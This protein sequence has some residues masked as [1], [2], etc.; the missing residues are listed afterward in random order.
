MRRLQIQAASDVSVKVLSY[1]ISV[2]GHVL[3]S[4]EEILSRSCT[5]AE[6][7]SQEHCLGSRRDN[8]PVPSLLRPNIISDKDIIQRTLGDGVDR[9]GL[10]G[11]IPDSLLVLLK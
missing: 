5:L 1:R 9:A 6:I 11:F 2:I 3:T 10:V 4:C 8:G 7:N